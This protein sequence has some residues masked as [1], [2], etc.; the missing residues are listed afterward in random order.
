M[1]SLSIS[2]KGQTLAA[3]SFDGSIVL[4]D[5]LSGRTRQTLRAHNEGVSA[6]LFTD[7]GQHLI[8]VGQ[9]KMLR[10]WSV[11]KAE[12]AVPAKT[13]IST[14]GFPVAIASSPNGFAVAVASLDGTIAILDVKSGTLKPYPIHHEGITHL[15]ISNDR[16][17]ASIGKENTLQVGDQKGQDAWKGKTSYAT[18][19]PDGKYLAVADGKDIVFRDAATGDIIKRFA[20]GHEGT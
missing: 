18:F 7:G 17:I 10:Q 6:L 1:T 9:D 5:P 8:S 19:T 15:A 11:S 16:R 20:G 13:T 2:P 4:L 3:G 14:I 12:L